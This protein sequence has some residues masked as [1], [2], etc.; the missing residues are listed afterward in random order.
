MIGL[1]VA[2]DLESSSRVLDILSK[3]K[4]KIVIVISHWKEIMVICDRFYKLENGL[5][6]EIQ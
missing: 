1:A 5:L 4:N 6:N 2:L 3:I